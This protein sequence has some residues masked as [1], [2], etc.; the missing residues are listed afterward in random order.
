MSMV[1]VTTP[2]TVD[3]V[4]SIKDIVD[5]LDLDIPSSSSDVDPSNE[6]EYKKYRTLDRIVK[7]ASVAIESYIGRTL[8]KQSYEERLS[9]NGTLNLQLYYHPVAEIA[10]IKE[11]TPDV[12]STEATLLP[13]DSWTLLDKDQ[14]LVFSN[15]GWD[16]GERVIV[17][18][19]DSILPTSPVPQYIVAYTAGYEL[20]D[21]TSDYEYKMPW[22]IVEAAIVAS[23]VWWHSA[24]I[25]PRVVMQKVDDLMVKYR[26]PSASGASSI[27]PLPPE[28][29][30]ILDA[31]TGYL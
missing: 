22:D 29:T 28:V 2:A 25:N 10:S 15:W 21:S 3:S 20:A 18:L 12:S 27:S 19:T 9:G 5:T 31:Y 23:K 17:G 24:K 8:R 30:N 14:G 1:R 16:R 26:F 7:G 13:T 11:G 6:E 4:V